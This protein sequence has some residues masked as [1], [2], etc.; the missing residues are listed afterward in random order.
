M[1]NQSHSHYYEELKTIKLKE[2]VE[3]LTKLLQFYSISMSDL[4]ESRPK[5]FISK[6]HIDHLIAGFLQNEE[7]VSIIIDKGTLPMTLIL[8]QYKTTKKRVEPYR[9]YIIA[10][11]MICVGQFEL[12][13]EYMPR[14]VTQK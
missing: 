12:L 9:K 5:H 3:E 6:K 10:V 2:E 8:K 7:L 1:N 11:I 14:E 13:K 4:Y